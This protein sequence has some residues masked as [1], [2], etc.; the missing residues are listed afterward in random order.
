M[1]RAIV[2]MKDSNWS[3]QFDGI[4]KIR[5]VAEFH[6]DLLSEENIPLIVNEL[7]QNLSNL[8]SGIT[9]LALMCLNEMMRKLH[10]KMYQFT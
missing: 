9:K 5:S 4:S 1:E 6:R 7:L 2:D 10:K 8:R 3:I